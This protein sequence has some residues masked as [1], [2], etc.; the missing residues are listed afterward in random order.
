VIDQAKNDV[1]LKVVNPAPKPVRARIQ[2]TGGKRPTSLRATQLSG[3]LS[4]ENTF[5]HPNRVAPV[6]TRSSVSSDPVELTF[7]PRSFL[8]LRFE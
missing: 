5:E 3:A 1:I 4:D 2:L 8:V 6:E 7:P